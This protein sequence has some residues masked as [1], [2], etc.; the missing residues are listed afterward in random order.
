MGMH[1]RAINAGS[2]DVSIVLYIVDSDGHTPE[3]G[4]VF[5]SAGI[6]LRYRRDFAAVVNITE[7]DLTSPA[8]TDAHEDGGFL[9]IGFGAYRLDLP[10]AACAAGADQVVVFGTVTGMIVHPIVINLQVPD[11]NAIQ[12]S[13]DATAANTLELFVEAL[14]QATGQLDSGSF[15]AG[16][17]DAAAIANG[18]IDAATFAAGAIDAAAIAAGAI[19]N[20][21][22]AADVQSTAYASNIIAQ[23]AGNALIFHN[24]DHLML[25]AVGSGADMTTEVADGTVLSNIMTIT[26]DTS[27]FVR[28]TDTLEI[29][30]TKTQLITSSSTLLAGIVSTGDQITIYQGETRRVDEGTEI[31]IDVDGTVSDLT[32]FTPRFGLTKVTANTGSATLEVS[33]TVN[34]AGAADQYLTFELTS[35]QTTGLAVDTAQTHGFRTSSNFAYTWTIG[36]FKGVD[37]NCPTFGVGDCSVQTRDV[38]CS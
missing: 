3:T 1:A 29:I 7:A 28:T 34:N 26:G 37:T 24:L 5:N 38:T 18:A 16:A 15:A 22:F 4:V 9:A 20:A 31:R 25:T 27:D 30:G 36:C 12:V 33:G 21:T 8:L 11:T 2:T 23:A 14:D 19:D 10:D 32:G 6:D 35:A 13:G 17:I